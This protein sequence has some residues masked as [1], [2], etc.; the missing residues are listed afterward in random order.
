MFANAVLVARTVH[1]VVRTCCPST[2]NNRKPLNGPAESPSKRCVAR[3]AKSRTLVNNAPGDDTGAAP[4]AEAE[5]N[6]SAW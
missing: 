4:N 6:A 1:V 2:S 5:S 3:L